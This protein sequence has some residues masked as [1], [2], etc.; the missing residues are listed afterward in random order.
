MRRLSIF[1]CL[2]L[3][4]LAAVAEIVEREFSIN[5]PME[6]KGRATYYVKGEI[7]GHG[8]VDLLVD[9][10]SGYLTINEVALE[11]L[12]RENRAD[13][14]RNLRG[15][16]ADGSE[17]EVPVYTISAL[18]IGENCWLRDVEAAVFPGK[19]RFI[20]GLS[21]LSKAG[22]FIFRFDPPTLVLSRCRELAAAS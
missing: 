20:L 1:F 13:Y 2:T 10:G 11:D 14:L 21:A 16:L 17:L 4:S 12:L 7:G 3:L 22:P 18:R 15:V 8:D 6:S 5:I 19:T 9:T